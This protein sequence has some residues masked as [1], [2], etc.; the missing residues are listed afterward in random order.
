MHPKIE[1]KTKKIE[2]FFGTKDLRSS[3][4]DLLFYN[5]VLCYKNKGSNKTVKTS[6]IL[7]CL[8]GVCSGKWCYPEHI[9]TVPEHIC[10]VHQN[11]WLHTRWGF[12]PTSYL[13]P[14]L[15]TI[16]TVL[17]RSRHLIQTGQPHQ[18]KNS[19]QLNFTRVTQSVAIETGLR[20]GWYIQC[21]RLWRRTFKSFCTSKT[22]S[23]DIHTR[24]T[25]YIY[26]HVYLCEKW[27]GVART[28]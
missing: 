8:R 13:S 20:W 27:Y 9:C 26:I 12:R 21:G 18:G 10:T 6:T 25:I 16:H 14:S 5:K 24:T 22:A 28:Q 4:R 15:E 1:K 23:T 11:R 17:A 2:N 3:K 7:W 19:I